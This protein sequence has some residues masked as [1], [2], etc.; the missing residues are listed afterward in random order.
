MNNPRFGQGLNSLRIRFTI[1]TAVFGLI[2]ATCGLIWSVQNAG[3]TG[4]LIMLGALIASSSFATFFMTGKLT[5]P[6]ENLRATTE[7]I[8]RGKFDAHVDVE[9][10]CEV[11]GLADSFQL[12]VKRLNANVSRINTLAYEDG[13]TGLPNRAVLQEVLGKIT[14]LPGALLF[15]DLDRFKHVNDVHGH[16]T[17]DRLL[18]EAADRIISEGL[19]ITSENVRFC[20][21]SQ[22]FTDHADSECRMLYRFAGDE[23]IA[24]VR[25]VLSHDE[26]ADMAGRIVNAMSQ[27]FEIDDRSIQIGASVGIALMGVDSKD[28]AEI[29]KF[30]DLAMYEAKRQG[31]GQFSFFDDHMRRR[32][33]E[34]AELEAEFANAIVDEQLTVFFQPKFRMSDNRRDGV[35][36]LVR[37]KH[38][39]RGLLTPGSFLDIVSSAGYTEKIGR[40]VLRLSAEQARIWRSQGIFDRISVNICPSQFADEKFAENLI[41]GVKALGVKPEDFELEITE[42]V[43]MSDAQLAEAHLRQLKSVGFHVAIDDFG[44]GYSN[45]SQLCRLPFDCLKIDRSLIEDIET[46]LN[47]RTIVG[48]AIAMAHGLGHK[49]VAEGVETEGQLQVIRMLGCDSVQGY[50]LGR[51]MPGAQITHEVDDTPVTLPLAS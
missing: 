28:P 47:A 49:V 27:P 3:M 39:T 30:A 8:A 16:Q 41:A 26:L 10:Q 6:I 32:A 36:A 42:R 44:V 50:L 21:T 33:L 17:G 15:I 13:V 51:P 40:E 24:I 5:R 29:I 9:C 11:G 38:P 22:S 12:M 37:W 23:F 7:A 43:A 4:T 20:V 46:D 31:R 25:G 18:R 34:R 45:L 1:M 19:A 35:E 14:P 48:A 2:I